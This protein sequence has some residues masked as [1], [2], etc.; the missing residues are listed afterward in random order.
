LPILL[1]VISYSLL[2]EDFSSVAPFESYPKTKVAT[3][4]RSPSRATRE[5]R[6]SGCSYA[7]ESKQV[8]DSKHLLRRRRH[9]SQ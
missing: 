5:Q 4:V 2:L 9:L 3:V 7:I 1:V 6:T 8:V